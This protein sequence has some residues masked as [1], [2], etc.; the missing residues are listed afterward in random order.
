[1]SS[2]VT[3]ITPSFLNH[4]SINEAKLRDVGDIDLNFLDCTLP[5]CTIDQL[6]HMEN[7]SKGRD[8]TYTTDKLWKNLYEKK[9]GKN[10][11]DFVIERMKHKNESFKRNQIYETKMEEL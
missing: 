11:F 6:M 5:H 3:K 1:M 4:L 7:F 8:L 2:E 9:F 10:D